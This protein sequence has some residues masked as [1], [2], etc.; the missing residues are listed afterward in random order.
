MIPLH[1]ASSYGH[2]DIAALL[3][4]HKTIVNSTDKWG[5]TP[6]HEAAQK[7]RTQLCSLLLAHG[8]DPY[9]QNQE[10]QRPIDLATA[11]DVK[12][13]LQDAMTQSLTAEDLHSSQLSLN[14][15]SSAVAVP[16]PAATVTVVSPSTETVTLPTGASMVLTVPIPLLPSRSCM[17]PAQGAESG[18]L[19]A[20]RDDFN[21]ATSENISNV[22]SLLNSLQLDHLSEMFEREQITLEI[23]A[24]M[25]HEDLK[26]IGVSAY[27]FRHKILK[28]I[29]QLRATIGEL[30]LETTFL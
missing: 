13:L 18:D 8:A 25:G 14:N 15:I 28:G 20:S 4:K 26:Q 16:P 5:Y 30:I 11:E 19:A 29:A 3:I 17:S 21:D 7:G 12:C 22:S 2:L 6:L 1:N 27:G 23:L 24:E 10:G 9:T